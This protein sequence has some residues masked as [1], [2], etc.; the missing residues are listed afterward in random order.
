MARQRIK[1]I[2]LVGSVVVGGLLRLLFMEEMEFKYDEKYMYLVVQQALEGGPWPWLGMRS[3]AAIRNPGMSLWV[4]NVLGF[5]F[6]TRDPVALG[7]AVAWLNTAALA[8]LGLFVWKKIPERSQTAWWWALGFAAVNPF[9]IVYH[10]K[11]WTQSVLAFFVVLFLWAFWERRHR[12]GAFFWGVI[13]AFLGQV[14][15]S[16]FFLAAAFVLS[17]LGKIEDRRTVRW[18]AWL[19]GSVVGSLPMIPWLLYLPSGH[20]GASLRGFLTE[21][22]QFRFWSFWFSDP[23]GLTLAHFL[24]QHRGS[25]LWVQNAEFMKYPLVGDASTYGVAVCMALSLA[26]ALLVFATAVVQIARKH[27]HR[28]R[29]DY[30]PT[31]HQA[32]WA[33][34]GIYGAIVPFSFAHVRRHYMLVTFPLEFVWFCRE[35]FRGLG[36]FAPGALATLL[37]LQLATSVAFLQFI[38]RNG[39]GP[40]GDYGQSYRLQKELGILQLDKI[41]VQ[42]D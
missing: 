25:G 19:C 30:D 26:L 12:A 15:M 10:R 6:Q 2:A 8:L 11:I 27:F 23:T 3:G 34:G 20:G 29:K 5:L 4:F 22:S 9:L 24:G 41:T 38:L 35:A 31:T 14:H 16:G 36:R 21:I 28:E 42:N 17:V 40:E 32:I 18:T 1:L 33:A 39:G 7:R 13:G 37:I